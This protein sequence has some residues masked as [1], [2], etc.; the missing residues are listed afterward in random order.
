MNGQ[1]AALDA[2][3]HQGMRHLAPHAPPPPAIKHTWRG[4]LPY[5]YQLPLATIG[6]EKKKNIQT[7]HRFSALLP[8]I[9]TEQ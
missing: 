2:K 1:Y 4:V 8:A 3:S 7:Q 9:T 6:N 5:T